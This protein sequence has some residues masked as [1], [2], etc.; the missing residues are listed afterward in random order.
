[1]SCKRILFYLRAAVLANG[2]WH[3]PWFPRCYGHSVDGS[4]LGTEAWP[5]R[6][7]GWE[8]L[9]LL[10]SDFCS[11]VLYTVYTVCSVITYDFSVCSV[12]ESVYR[13]LPQTTPENVSKNYSQ[14]SLDPSTRYPNLNTQVINA[15][16]VGY[17]HM[18]TCIYTVCTCANTHTST[19]KYIHPH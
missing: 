10:E 13:L 5:F 2:D 19:Y 8:V 3:C 15:S 16:Q 18:H 14:Y 4:E 6:R 9:N 12:R 17:T 7:P 11:D 1:M